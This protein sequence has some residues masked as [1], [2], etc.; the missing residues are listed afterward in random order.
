MTFPIEATERF[1]RINGAA[2]E[3]FLAAL[4]GKVGKYAAEW[5]L[6]DVNYFTH[7]ANIIFTCR[8]ER[9]GN[10]VLK[11]AFPDELLWQ[12]AFALKFYAEKGLSCRLYEYSQEDGLMLIERMDPGIP[13]HAAESD[14]IKRAEVFV[15]LYKDY[16]LPFDGEGQPT[17]GELVSAFSEKLDNDSHFCKYS[18]VRDEIYK[19]ISAGYNKKC[20]LHGD[21]NQANILSHGGSYKAIDPHGFIGDPVFDIPRYL[22]SELSDSVKEARDFNKAVV[23]HIAGALGLPESLLY[24]LLMLDV[25]QIMGFHLGNPM[26][27]NKRA[28]HIKRCAA[29]YSLYEENKAG[30]F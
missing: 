17:V 2:G 1:I 11:A 8:S 20:L 5:G 25:I 16:H 3:A 21:L 7:S 12:E 15:N 30:D 6:S 28:F 22:L 14:P 18:A 26:T 23:S 29:A 24:A 19:N 9:Y 27:D 13:L 10:V 4:P